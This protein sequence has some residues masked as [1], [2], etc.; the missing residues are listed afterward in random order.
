MSTV[1]VLEPNQFIL[2]IDLSPAE[3]GELTHEG[4]IAAFA[5]QLDNPHTAHWDKDAYKLA[6]A[7]VKRIPTFLNENDFKP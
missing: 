4:P 6:L 2:T 7:L 1:S 3:L 5:I